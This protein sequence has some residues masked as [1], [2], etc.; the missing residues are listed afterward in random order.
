MG[1]PYATEIIGVFHVNRIGAIKGRS[2]WIVVRVMYANRATLIETPG[3][4]NAC[5]FA[6]VFCRAKS[7]LVGV[8]RPREDQ[9]EQTYKQACEDA[10]V[11]YGWS[12]VRS[13]AGQRRP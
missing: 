5:A 1:S 12:H 13:E 8:E 4:L 2:L 7:L 10:Q 3:V 6:V 11:L 9:N